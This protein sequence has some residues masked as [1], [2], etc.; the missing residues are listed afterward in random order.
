MASNVSEKPTILIVQGSFQ[1]PLVYERLEKILSSHGYHTVHPPLPSC[2]NIDDANFPSVTLVDDAI[3]VRMA[4]IRLVEY[5]GKT[6]V[7][8]MHSYGGLVGSEAIPEDLSYSKRKAQNLPG[9]IIYLFFFAAFVLGEGQSVMGTFGE[10][11]HNDVKPDG[12]FYL[13]DGGKLLYNDLPETEATL[14]ASRLIPQS[15][16]VQDTK[17]TRA[18]YKYIPST[19]LMCENDQAAPLQYQEMFAASSKATEVEKCTSGHS[20]MLSQPE[21]L[22]QKIIAAAEKALA[23]EAS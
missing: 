3:A 12:R 11:P 18:A 17:L 19:Y 7:V 16:K 8:V 2:S 10:S 14:W 23:D 15:H 4:L 6:V 22:A 5:E 1:T 9:G 13:K 21:M 20:P